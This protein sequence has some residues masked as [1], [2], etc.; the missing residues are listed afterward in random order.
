MKFNNDG[1]IESGGKV[2]RIIPVIEMAGVTRVELPAVYYHVPSDVMGWRE[3]EGALSAY[4]AYLNS[5]AM[6]GYGPMASRIMFVVQV[7]E[8]MSDFGPYTMHWVEGKPIFHKI[9]RY[10]D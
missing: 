3:G 9:D 7:M 5:Q 10:D 4:T 8:N 1:S 6:L 2:L